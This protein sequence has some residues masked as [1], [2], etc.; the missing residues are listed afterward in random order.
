M[1]DSLAS[2]IDIAP[3]ILEHEQ[4][5]P[6]V[7]CRDKVSSVPLTM[8][9][10]AK[11]LLI[12]FNDGAAKLG[13]ESPHA[14]ERCAPN[15]GGIPFMQERL[16]GELYDLQSTPDETNNLWNSNNYKHIRGDLALRKN[17]YLTRQMD[18]SSRLIRIA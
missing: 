10:I 7:V 13:F 18:E 8:T 17:Q 15:R 9:S 2:T 11:N 3:S 14:S 5:T 1:V 12:E 6:I 4:L 16:E